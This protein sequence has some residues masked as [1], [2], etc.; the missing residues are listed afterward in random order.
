MKISQD[1]IKM[2][3][4][5]IYTLFKKMIFFIPYVKHKDF[6]LSFYFLEYLIY[7]YALW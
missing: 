7:F 4:K 3:V 1:D 6:Y 2:L 5:K